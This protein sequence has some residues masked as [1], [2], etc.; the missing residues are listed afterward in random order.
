VGAS[1]DGWHARARRVYADRA[2]VDQLSDDQTRNMANVAHLPGIQSA[3]LA[4][5]D[6]HWGYG[7]CIGGVCATDPEEEGVI[8]PGGVGYDIKLRLPPPR[9]R[10]GTQG[11]Q[12]QGAGPGRPVVQRRAFRR[13]GEWRDR[14]A[15]APNRRLLVRGRLG[16]R[17]RLWVKGRP[18]AHRGWWSASGADPGAISGGP[19]RVVSI[20]SALGSG[21]HFSR[22]G[23]RRS[24][25]HRP[26]PPLDCARARSP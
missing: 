1:P 14:E 10:S 13:G 17:A 24:S 20:R 8:S 3:S 21:N 6:I 22:S 18:A 15:I 11:H 16:L 2:L 7:F 26:R 25:T 12:G 19:T 5:P 4:M 9:H 23:G